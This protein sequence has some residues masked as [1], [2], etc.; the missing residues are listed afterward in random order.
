MSSRRRS[1]FIQ[2]DRTGMVASGDRGR[3]QPDGERDGL[4]QRMPASTQAHLVPVSAGNDPAAL[5]AGCVFGKR[6]RTRPRRC[7]SF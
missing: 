4:G 7:R 2:I 6:R 1:G 5:P 3:R